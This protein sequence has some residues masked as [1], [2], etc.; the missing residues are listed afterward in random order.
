[1]R[2]LIFLFIFIII[3]YKN[4]YAIKNILYLALLLNLFILH[5]DKIINFN[6]LL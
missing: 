6:K 5:I 2:L 1:M 3:Y 4:I